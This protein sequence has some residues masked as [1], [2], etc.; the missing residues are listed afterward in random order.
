MKQEILQALNKQISN[1]FF[2]SFLY[3][4]ISNFYYQ[5]KFD[6]LGKHYKSQSDEE[7]GHAQKIIDYLLKFELGQD[8]K[9][10]LVSPTQEWSSLYLPL[11]AA[12]ELEKVTTQ[13]INELMLLTIENDDYSTQD[14]LQWYVDEQVTE[15]HEANYMLAQAKLDGAYNGL[16]LRLL[17]DSLLK[18]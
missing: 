18:D 7:R 10:P 3:L 15:E 2:N 14:F 4:S 17:N 11:D 5:Q 9:L 8:I 13:Q 12:L 6:G 1:E 16:A